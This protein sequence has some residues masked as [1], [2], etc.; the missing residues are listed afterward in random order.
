MT[1][2]IEKDVQEDASSF[3]F[4]TSKTFSL[5][6]DLSPRDQWQMEADDVY[7]SAIRY[8]RSGTFIRML[9]RDILV[10]I[11]PYDLYKHKTSDA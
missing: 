11:T 1:L 3:L 6:T 9:I 5:L 10:I 2:Y 8:V 4:S 7:Q